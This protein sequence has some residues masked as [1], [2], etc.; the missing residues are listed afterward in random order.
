[1]YWC[2]QVFG[3]TAYFGYLSIFVAL[4]AHNNR[5]L[6][7]E[8]VIALL[9][10]FASHGLRALIRARGWLQLSAGKLAAR[11][12]LASCVFAVLIQ[13]VVTP[14]AVAI[15]AVTL[16]EQRA[17]WWVYAAA[18][19][20]LFCAWSFFYIAFQWLFRYRDSEMQRLELEAGLREAELRALKAQINPH[21]LFNCLNNVRSLIAEDSER[22]REMLL[23]LSGLLRYALESG[24]RER[25][26]L[27]QELDI[28]RSFLELEKLQF[29]ERLAWRFE[30]APHTLEVMVPPMMI[31]Q[32]VENAI[33]H[34]IEKQPAG[35]E[36]VIT[37]QNDSGRLRI[38]VENSGT[39]EAVAKPGF[40]LANARE[41]L[42]LLCGPN[43]ALSLQNTE[44][45][46]VAAVAEI[47]LQPT[48]E[49]Y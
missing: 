12:C 7:L 9:H 26:P 41:R 46:R 31:Q 34:G 39:L 42:R 17:N 3:W 40:G 48:C 5:L 22:A 43:A 10:L 18:S 23:R 32:L 6:A 49:P 25:V 11:L 28:V 35:G 21:F 19:T 20:V 15:G 47:P 38:S 2:L 44:D 14:L 16:S 45:R 36:I 37:A 8:P 33:K 24:N 29:E 4:Y 27:S 30:I 13:V 1:M